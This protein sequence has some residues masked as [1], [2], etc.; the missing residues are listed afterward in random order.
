MINLTPHPIVIRRPDGDW[1]IPPSGS[2]ARVTMQETVAGAIDG[3]PVVTRRAGHVTG[4]V[5]DSAGLP[6]P[7]LVSAM[8]LAALPTGT[9]YVYAPD[10]GPTAIRNADGQVVAVTRLVAA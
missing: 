2:I 4:L 6:V 5:R 1:T 3:V 10:T 8:V 7:C 9:P